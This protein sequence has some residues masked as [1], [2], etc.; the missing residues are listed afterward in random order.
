MVA[1]VNISAADTKGGFTFTGAD[2]QS[3]TTVLN[4]VSG[5][6][7]ITIDMGGAS[8][9]L[10]ISSVKTLNT[11]TLDAGAAPELDIGKIHNVTASADINLTLGAVSDSTK[12][13]DVSVMDAKGAFVLNAGSYREG[14]D[15]QHISGGTVTMTFG[16]LT[17][18]FS[19]SAVFSDGAFTLSGGGGPSFSAAIANGDFGGNFTITM[20][21]IG[22]G[23]HIGHGANGMT[24]SASG[25][26][27]GT[28]ELD[29]ISVESTTQSTDALTF[30]VTLGEDSIADELSFAEGAGKDFV[31]VRNFVSGTDK[32]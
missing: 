27:V 15:F 16:D 20:A 9:A 22:N 1:N 12:A 24:I 30:E 23:I 14:M 18:N 29:T 10:T 31:V 5:D 28:L 26:I 8:G 3:S 17:D 21:E 7:A 19:A 6:G 25:T 13:L 32:I 11:F 4:H 2:L